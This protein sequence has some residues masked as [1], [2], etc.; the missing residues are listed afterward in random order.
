MVFVLH[1]CGHAIYTIAYPAFF[2][3]HLTFKCKHNWLLL[4]KVT[5]EKFPRE[6]RP[7]SLCES[8][9]EGSGRSKR[10]VVPYCYKGVLEGREVAP[11]GVGPPLSCGFSVDLRP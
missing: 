7:E 8:R 6:V 9:P 1:R 2:S 10:S 3:F 11:K 5:Q 4:L